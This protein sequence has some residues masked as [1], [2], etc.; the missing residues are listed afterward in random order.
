[1][2]PRRPILWLP[3]DKALI[4]NQSNSAFQ[5]LHFATVLIPLK[6]C[7]TPINKEPKLF[8]RDFFQSLKKMFS[9]PKA[10]PYV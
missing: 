8:F 9:H 3:N 5:K 1:M 10:V 4:Q 2:G 7:I 6:S